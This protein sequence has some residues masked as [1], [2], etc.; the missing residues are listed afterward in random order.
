MPYTCIIYQSA[1]GI[2]TITLNRPER[3]NAFNT[4]MHDE[5]SSAI[6]EV[7]SDP[8]V[9]VLLLTGSG[10]A[11]CSGQ[12]LTE[13]EFTDS[14]TFIDLG[15]GLD[16]TY[17]PLV[18]KIRSLG[19]PVVCAVNGVAAGA[20]AGLAMACDIVVAAKSARF[21]QAFSKI[22]LAPDCGSTHFL[23]RLIGDVRAR[24]LMMTGEAIDAETAENWGMI[25]RSFD[26]DEFPAKTRE[27]TM[28]LAAQPAK[29]LA[30]IK[31]LLQLSLTHSFDDQLDNERDAQRLL[32]KTEDYREGVRAFL[33][34]RPPNFKGN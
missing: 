28:S 33:E 3:L 19:I 22:G 5:L 10:R 13:R 24:A 20:G 26:D 34:K 29:A 8:E 2:A 27:L 16:T 31:S 30:G 7:D 9:R 21:I 15:K 25:W 6:A 18:R 17:N 14:N 11:F 12:D 4:Q 1:N 23:P 32:G